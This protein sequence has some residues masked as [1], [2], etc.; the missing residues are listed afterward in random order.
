MAVNPFLILL[1]TAIQDCGDVARIP[2][3][4]WWTARL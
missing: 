4:R 1:I 2:D 3:D